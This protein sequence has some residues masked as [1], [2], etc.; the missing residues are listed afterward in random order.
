MIYESLGLLAAAAIVYGVVRHKPQ[1]RLAW[2]LLAASQALFGLGDI[3]YFNAYG[4]SP[5]YPSGADGIYLVAVVV[6]AVALLLLAS[7]ST[8][9]RDL[10]SYVDAF[11]IAL[12]TGLLI[13]SALFEGSFGS[14]DHP[15]ARVVSVAYP[16][17]DLVLLAAL[18]H[19][20]FVRGERTVAFYA[21][22]G[23]VML[24]LVSDM[25]YMVPALTSN[26]VQGTWRDC[27]WLG[28]YVLAGAAGLHPSM[29]SFVTTATAA[30]ACAP[31]GASRRR[32]RV[33][34]RRRRI[35]EQAVT[36]NV[37]VYPLAGFGV[38][39]AGF[40]VVRVA[41]LIRELERAIAAAEESERRF[42]LVFERAPIGIS[43][44]R[45]GIMTETNPTFQRML[46]YTGDELARMHYTEVTEPDE[47]WLAM[48]QELDQG[49]RDRFAID[50]RYVRKDGEV[51]NSHVHVALDLEDGLGISLVEDVTER[52]RARGAAPA[53]AED[54]GGR[55]AGRRRRARLQQSDDRGDRV[56]RPP[57]AGAG[58]RR[59]P[60]G[61]SRCDP[62]FGGARRAS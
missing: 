50:K 30:P 1:A 52:L 54:G 37:A 39:A 16:L 18:L 28:S 29:R 41:S 44:G 33:G 48:Q 59:F 21:L 25:W 45:D 17:I 9:G 32:R 36:G 3:V 34:R 27:G 19:V 5:P 15:L 55:E 62:R 57:A 58:A 22:A 20:F 47:P 26:Y 43:V 24:L 6:F 13:W 38:L 53:G 8:H 46:G 51:V 12:A 61:A 7:R 60:H 40:V 56:Q 31:C 14:G 2:L 4:S 23:S 11:V 35:I 42:R 10:L 49:S